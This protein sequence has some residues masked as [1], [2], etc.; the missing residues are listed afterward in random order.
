MV[1]GIERGRKEGREEEGKVGYKLGGITTRNTHT[2]LSPFWGFFELRGKRISLL[3]YSFRRWILV[4]N[5]SSD[6]FFLR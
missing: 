3:R 2:S 5:D 1:R 6:R 4:C